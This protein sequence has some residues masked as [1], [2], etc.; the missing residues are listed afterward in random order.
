MK[1]YEAQRND[2]TDCYNKDY[3]RQKIYR[4]ESSLRKKY[5]ARTM[6]FE[7]IEPWLR[8]IASKAWFRK[9]FGNNTVKDLFVAKSARGG[10][11]HRMCGI[12]LAPWG[13][14][15]IVVL[16]EFAHHVA[17]YASHRRQFVRTFICL[18]HHVLGKGVADDF[19]QCCKQHGV[20][21]SFARKRP[22]REISEERREEL[23][24]Q[25]AAARIAKICKKNG[26][27]VKV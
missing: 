20:K 13:Y 3:Q 2:W 14:N 25:L 22:K 18:L 19:K 1:W 16:H 4:A 17:R 11:Y 23:R 24:Q 6:K 8:D 5:T 15:D 9:R 7:E 12:Y 10:C 26:V 27:S 21:Y